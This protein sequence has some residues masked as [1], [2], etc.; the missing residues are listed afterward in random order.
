MFTFNVHFDLSPPS[1]ANWGRIMAAIGYSGAEFHPDQVDLWIASDH[2]RLQ[3]VK[4]GQP[5]HVQEDRAS[6]IFKEYE[7]QVEVNLNE[8]QPT[9]DYTMW[10]CDLSNEYVD[11]NADYRS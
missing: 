8:K 2:D 9:D 3:L 6:S 1:D 5:F 11:I 4:G 10:T 7:I